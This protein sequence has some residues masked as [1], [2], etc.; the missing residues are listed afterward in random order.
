MDER[1]AGE[2]GEKGSRGGMEVVFI[3]VVV[4]VGSRD[5]LRVGYNCL[6]RAHP[7]RG[8]LQPPDGQHMVS[9]SR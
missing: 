6:S 4:V 5:P 1:R 9:W 8:R 2:G 7:L 3:V